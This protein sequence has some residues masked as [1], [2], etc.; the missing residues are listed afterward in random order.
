MSF[1]YFIFFILLLIYSFYIVKKNKNDY[2]IIGSIFG[3]IYF[4]IIP[5]GIFLIQNGTMGIDIQSTARWAVVR[6][7]SLYFDD[8]MEYFLGLF[9]MLTSIFIYTKVK[10][11]KY[12]ESNFIQELK[13]LPSNKS[14]I[15][16]LFIFLVMNF[17][18]DAMIPSYITHWAEKAEYFNH[19]FGTIAQ[20]F[21]FFLVGLKFF[22]LIIATNLFKNNMKLA[23]I[24]LI[25]AAFIDVFFS[26]NR[27]FSLVVGLVLFILLFKNKYF[28]SI[29]L[30]IVISIPLIVFM[31]LWPYIRSTMSYMSFGDA[32]IKSLKFLDNVESLI[33][34]VI[35]DTV[36][37][38]DFLVSFAIIQ[39]FPEK[40]DYFY[41]TSILKIFT[42]FIPRSLWPDKWDSIAIEMAQIYHPHAKGFSLATTL[43][44]EIFANGGLIS[45]FIVPFLL[46]IILSISF[47]FLKKLYIT[48]DFSFFAFAIT[49]L[50]M[51]SNFSDVFLQLI[52][53]SIFII[54][55][56]KLLN[57]RIKI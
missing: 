12:S 40:Y 28:K 1:I 34:N 55:T 9:L 53:I 5:F 25:S 56:K 7:A 10:I 57:T 19:R 24:I 43:Y 2:L 51:R 41:G 11:K 15:V 47:T 36:E 52:S 21:N 6:D 35:F 29:M 22:L 8:I 13:A 38:A 4:N 30:L 48:L 46:L 18:K 23:I 14:L 37:G 20:I 42:L 32:A 17:S 31:T 3:L 49:F 33:L 16:I 27:I 39:D 44:G 50:T 45:L 26:A 54:L